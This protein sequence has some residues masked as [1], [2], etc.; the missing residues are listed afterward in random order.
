MLPDFFEAGWSNPPSL[1]GLLN[2]DGTASGFSLN[3]F[4]NPVLAAMVDSSSKL[5]AVNWQVHKNEYF[6]VPLQLSLV[7]FTLSAHFLLNT[8][9]L[10]KEN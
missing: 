6:V 8:G 9:S 2:I 1:Y 3:L 5:S 4:F 10:G 7:H